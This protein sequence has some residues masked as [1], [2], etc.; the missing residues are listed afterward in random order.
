VSRQ[1]NGQRPTTFIDADNTLW[2]TDKVF[3]EAQL[4][5]LGHVERA[6]FQK[7]TTND[8]L[9]FVRELD[10][11]IAERHHAR[12]RYPPRLLVRAIALV[13]GGIGPEAA[14]KEVWANV[15]DDPIAPR[16]VHA[17]EIERQ[18]VSDLKRLPELRSGVL[19]G[20]PTLVGLGCRIVVFT[21][22]NREKCDLILRHYSLRQYVDQIFEGPKNTDTFR[23]LAR[24]RASGLPTIIVGDQLDRD[25]APA[26]KAGF[27]TI[28]FPGG[29]HPKWQVTNEKE[30]PDYRIESFEQ[31]AEIV[32]QVMLKDANFHQRQI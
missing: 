18:F 20:L 7:A 24:L 26:Q 2:D 10:Q 1:V 8:R 32:R 30:A 12:L 6:T 13:L 11:L 29:F 16:V 31:V 14:A 5:L 9:A 3:A 21:E 22:G 4:N 19:E 15:S 28:H 17:E 27:V 23:R 25:I